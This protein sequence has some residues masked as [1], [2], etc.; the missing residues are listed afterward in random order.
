MFALV[1]QHRCVTERTI[2]DK[3]SRAIGVFSNKL[4]TSRPRLQRYPVVAKNQCNTRGVESVPVT[5]TQMTLKNRAGDV[6]SPGSIGDSHVGVGC[7]ENDLAKSC[8][9]SNSVTAHTISNRMTYIISFFVSEI[10]HCTLA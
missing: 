1:L 10:A 4:D 2:I 9:L 8:W 5:P 7:Q 3:I 6:V